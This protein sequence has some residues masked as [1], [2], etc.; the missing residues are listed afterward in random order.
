M[1]AFKFDWLLLIFIFSLSLN[2]NRKI[3]LK[4]INSSNYVLFSYFLFY[5]DRV[6][7]IMMKWAR[8]VFYY[9]FF[10]ICTS[11]WW[12]KVYTMRFIINNYNFVVF[13][14][15]FFFLLFFFFYYLNNNWIKT[16]LNQI[17]ITVF[18]SGVF[19]L[20]KK[21]LFHL[22]FFLFY[23]INKITLTHSTL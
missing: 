16:Q 1:P 18:F 23:K 13:I 12:V 3:Y 19:S 15:C 9:S 20:H 21:N 11:I 8:C 22:L 5:I 6:L 17:K 10:S 4:L 2:W 14:I 7:F